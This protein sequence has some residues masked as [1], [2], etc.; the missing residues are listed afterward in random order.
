MVFSILI[1]AFGLAFFILLSSVTDPQPNHLSF[2]TTPLA[3]LRTFSMMLG[4]MDFV[5]TFVQP[6]HT[7]G[8][9]YPYASFIILC[10]ILEI[11]FTRK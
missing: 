11:S 3:M 9:P 5:G 7:N 2:K 6:Y 10:K 4:E 8:L 1:I